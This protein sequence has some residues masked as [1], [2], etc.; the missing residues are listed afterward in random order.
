MEESLEYYIVFVL[1]ICIFIFLT[2]AWISNSEKILK[3]HI[4]LVFVVILM[5]IIFDGCILTKLE[6]K[7]RKNHDRYT[8]VDPLINLF[9]ISRATGSIIAI[10][11]MIVAAGISMYKLH[12]LNSE[13]G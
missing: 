8:I 9:K 6:I 11:A 13:K 4:L 2:G 7:L 3:F 10:I 1:H 5:Y 12:R